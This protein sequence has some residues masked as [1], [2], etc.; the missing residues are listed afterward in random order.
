MCLCY[1]RWMSLEDTNYIVL[2]IC[3]PGKHSK[4][5]KEA[6]HCL[7]LTEDQICIKLED[8][9]GYVGFLKH[10]RVYTRVHA[11]K[12]AYV[13]LL[14]FFYLESTLFST[15]A[16]LFGISDTVW[17]LWWCSSSHNSISC[18]DDLLLKVF[19]MHKLRGSLSHMKRMFGCTDSGGALALLSIMH[20][21]Q[22][23]GSEKCSL[24]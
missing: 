21:W 20:G 5:Q 16:V 13:W 6:E 15:A 14:T 9:I 2:S 18:L 3:I 24:S 7:C 12:T 11:Q 22:Y 19:R 10:S 4:P 23:D 17:Y 1:N 8:G